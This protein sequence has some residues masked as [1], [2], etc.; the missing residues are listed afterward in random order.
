MSRHGFH[1]VLNAPSDEEEGFLDLLGYDIYD[2]ISRGVAGYDEPLETYFFNLEGSWIFGTTHV[3]ITTISELQGT[4]SAIFGGAALPFN[5]EGLL[6]IAE[7]FET[8]EGILS[9]GEA[10]MMSAGL[11]QDYL[12]NHLKLAKALRA[13]Q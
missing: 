3:E 7:D 10:A 13:E 6:R 12:D 2:W 9:P 4:L 11:P 8:E 5:M 1:N